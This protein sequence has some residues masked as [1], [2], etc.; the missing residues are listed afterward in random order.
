MLSEED[1]RSYVAAFNRSD[2]DGFSRFY[3]PDVEFIG[4]PGSR[5]GREEVVSLYR[6]IRTRVNEKV[7]IHALVSGE[8]SIVADMETELYALVDWPELKSGALQKG[9]TRRSQNFIWYDMA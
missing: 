4:R 3:A 8:H 2:F 5:T 1:F 9:E 6:D 7:T